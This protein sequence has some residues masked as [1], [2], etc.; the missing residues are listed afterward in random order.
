MTA[1]GAASILGLA[2]AARA[3]PR[4][5]EAVPGRSRLVVHVYK[6]GLLS[7]LA[8]D[9]HFHATHW[10]ATARL[11]PSG[12]GPMRVE[13]VVRSASLADQQPALSAGDR[14]KVD[15]QAAQTLGAEKFPEIRFTSDRLI[16]RAAPG[17]APDAPLEGEL[18]GTLALHGRERP[19]TIPVHA[20]RD[21]DG[22]RVRGAVRFKQT[23]Y[24]V[25][26]FSGFLGTIA[27]KDEVE[28]ELDLVL[29]PATTRSGS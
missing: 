26:P 1:I 20:E 18:V 4:G 24:G 21:G 2:G 15:R 22:W 7:G 29:A 11:E 16:R 10:S 27:V 17:A 9:H 12:E 14:A 6:R 19:L 23:D 25:E 28:V 13:V 3:E 5:W 8:H